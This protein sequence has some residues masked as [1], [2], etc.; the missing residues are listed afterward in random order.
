MQEA[1]ELFA[2]RMARREFG[3]R[4][5]VRTCNMGAYEPTLKFAEYNAFVGITR[6][7]ATTGHN[8]NFTVYRTH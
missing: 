5:D 7:G 3:Q 6:S 2:L 1:A 4:A 8:I